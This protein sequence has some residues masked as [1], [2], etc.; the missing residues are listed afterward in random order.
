MLARDDFL[1]DWVLNRTIDDH[2]SGQNGALT[3]TA[4]FVPDGSAGLVYDETGMLLL[5][6]GVQMAATRRYLWT[7]HEAGV[8]VFFDDGRPFH[9]FVP[10]GHAAGTDHPCGEDYYT[11]RYD[12]SDWPR[13]TARWT[14]KGPRKDY[15]STSIYSR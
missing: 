12:F 4:R 13:W 6:T 10:D 15:V 5:A 2:L 3:G 1:G 7:F 8:E 9:G 11:V 14:V